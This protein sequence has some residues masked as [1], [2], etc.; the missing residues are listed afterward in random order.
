MKWLVV[1]MS[2]ASDLQASIPTPT[3]KSAEAVTQMCSRDISGAQGMDCLIFTDA[4]VLSV[5]MYILMNLLMSM[6]RLV[7]TIERAEC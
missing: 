6:Q 1:E 2:G 4:I 5:M 3:P 7:K